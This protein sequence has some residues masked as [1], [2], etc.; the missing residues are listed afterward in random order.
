MTKVKVIKRNNRQ[1]RFDRQKIVKVS[2]ATGLS[3]LESENL[4]RAVFLWL[5][6]TRKQYVKSTEIRDKVLELMKKSHP[7][8]ANLFEQYQKTK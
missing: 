8:N 6:A 5:N 3:K 1:E 2:E 4:A 7:L